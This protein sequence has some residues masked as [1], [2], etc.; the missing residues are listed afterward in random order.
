M[1]EH[2]ETTIMQRNL[3]VMKNIFAF[4]YHLIFLFSSAEISSMG[5]NIN[6]VGKCVY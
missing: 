2:V 5:T 3:T 1:E 4:Q 6:K